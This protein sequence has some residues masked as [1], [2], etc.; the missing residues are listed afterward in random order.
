MA[1]Q[2]ATLERCSRAYKPEATAAKKLLLAALARV[3]PATAGDLA[4]L[5]DTL[6]FLRAYPDD[7]A[8]L[9]LVIS[10][11][12]ALRARATRDRRLAAKLLDTGLPGGANVYEYHFGIARRL[13]RLCPG[14]LSIDWPSFDDQMPIQYVL[15]NLVARAE[16][17]GLEDEGL[18]LEE[19]FARARPPHLTDL[20]YFLRVLD[21]SGL[22]FPVQESLYDTLKLPARYRLGDAGS[23]RAEVAM[24]KRSLQWQTSELDRS[25]FP[26]TPAIVAPLALPSPLRPTAGQRVIDIGLRAM[27]ARRLEIH[28]LIYANPGDVTLVEGDRGVAVA[29][30]GTR[31]EYRG[32]LESLYF[33]LVLKNGVPMAYGP[34]AACLGTCEMGINL[35][36]EFRGAEA[37]HFYAQ[38]MRVLYHALGVRY[39]F[40]LPY[41]MGE[42]N[43]EAIDSGAF[44]F[45]RKLGFRPTNPEVEELARGEEA[46]TLAAPG[47]R[48]NRAM[49]RRLSH[50]SACFDLSEGRCRP[51]DVA[52][53]ALRCSDT[54]ARDH[55]GR[56]TDATRAAAGTVAQALG[57]TRTRA[58]SAGERRALGEM[59]P[60]LAPIAA[61]GEWSTQEK[62]ALTRA[63]RAKGATSE[64]H[65]ARLLAAHLRLAAALH[66]VVDA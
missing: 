40:L 34:A 29:L 27:A 56:H 57:L 66:A 28:S 31:R 5:H 25:R 21:R 64:L 30:I 32:A 15:G 44:W 9:D 23:G 2:V 51:L 37:H 58:W 62:Q 20:E 11:T 26:L 65:A 13:A 42:D 24:R 36:P 17:P 63:I 54:I 14:A 59:A 7:A 8:T 50:T 48:S 10:M 53:L 12:A 55:C 18:T 46:R 47:H 52:K 35:F 45:Y 6:C 1:S 16:V 61:L 3:P 22:P 38:L 43:D 49:L 60:I 19:W 4:R 41:G 39:F 33:A